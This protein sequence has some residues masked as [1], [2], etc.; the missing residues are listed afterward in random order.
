[1]RLNDFVMI[2]ELSSLS[3]EKR[4][5]RLRALGDEAAS[6]VREI[7]PKALTDYKE[8]VFL[9][10]VPPFKESCWH[11]GRI[12]DDDWLPYFT[13]KATGDALLEVVRSRPDRRVTVLCGHTH[14]AGVADLLPNLKVLTGGADYG[15]PR[16]EQ[17]LD[18]A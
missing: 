7:L 6:F 14:G 18:V 3:R 13:C 12:S 1:M 17:I 2:E 4:N 16:I 8:V 9:T 11:E 15:K 10:H 5:E